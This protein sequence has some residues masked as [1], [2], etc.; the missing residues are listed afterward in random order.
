MC[1][2]GLGST[3]QFRRAVAHH[4]YIDQGVRAR[5]GHGSEAEGCVLVIGGNVGGTV[6]LQLFPAGRGADGPL[7]LT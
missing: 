2:A 5:D 1:E 3:T 4:S 6:S 7:R